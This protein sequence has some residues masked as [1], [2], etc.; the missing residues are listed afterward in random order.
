[1]HHHLA[2]NFLAETV[3][4]EQ[5]VQAAFPPFCMDKLQDVPIYALQ[6]GSDSSVCPTEHCILYAWAETPVLQLMEQF[7]PWI[8]QRYNYAGAMEARVYEHLLAPGSPGAHA[9]MYGNIPDHQF[10]SS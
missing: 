9:E 4:G 2:D 7:V 8:L 10:N 5:L 1:M 6:V 3:T